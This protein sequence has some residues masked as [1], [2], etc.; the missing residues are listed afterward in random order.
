MHNSWT[1]IR[2]KQGQGQRWPGVGEGRVGEGAGSPAPPTGE[3]VT[4]PTPPEIKDRCTDSQ[5]KLGEF[6]CWEVQIGILVSSS[7]AFNYE[8]GK[9]RERFRIIQNGGFR[10]ANYSGK[11]WS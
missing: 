2:S 8:H 7:N 5:G 1:G 11:I 4:W 3:Q 10:M 9:F 6:F